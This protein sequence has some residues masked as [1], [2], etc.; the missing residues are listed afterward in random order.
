MTRQPSPPCPVCA[1]TMKWDPEDERHECTGMVQ[2]CFTVEGSGP[3]RQL[4]L[5]ASSSGEDAEL[6]ST[7]PW[8]E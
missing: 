5:T 2:H 4:M 3:G 7:Y 6:F 1:A 8:P